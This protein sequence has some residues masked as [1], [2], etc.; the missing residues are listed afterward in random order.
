MADWAR[1]HGPCQPLEF[2]GEIEVPTNLPPAW[3]DRVS[4]K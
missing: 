2:P 3:R 1:D 4:V